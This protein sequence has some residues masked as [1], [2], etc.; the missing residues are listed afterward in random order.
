[1]R[2]VAER[3][4]A[5]VCVGWVGLAKQHVQSSAASL[6]VDSGAHPST[7]ACRLTPRRQI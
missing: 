5:Q 4:R 1:M 2:L 6:T 7:F 3:D